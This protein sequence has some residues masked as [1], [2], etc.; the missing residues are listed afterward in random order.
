[1]LPILA[2]FHLGSCCAPSVLCTPLLVLEE[3]GTH[4]QQL[5]W[6]FVLSLRLWLLEPMLQFSVP[7]L[8]SHSGV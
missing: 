7:N 3:S 1:M 6:A 5:V 8:V 4:G 2:A